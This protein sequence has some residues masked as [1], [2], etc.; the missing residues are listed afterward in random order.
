MVDAKALRDL[1]KG[2]AELPWDADGWY[3]VRLCTNDFTSYHIFICALEEVR[4]FR[5]M[6]EKHVQVGDNMH[7][8][9]LVML[10]EIERMDADWEDPAKING[11][12]LILGLLIWPFMKLFGG[13][14]RKRGR[15]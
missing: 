13:G 7:D 1:E 6:V 5:Y 3:I 2:L 11:C 4:E 12:G 10:M 8:V 15:R 14:K 9:A